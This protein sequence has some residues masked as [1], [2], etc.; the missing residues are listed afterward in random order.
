[1]GSVKWIFLAILDFLVYLIKSFLYLLLVMLLFSVFSGSDSEMP[2][3]ALI[4]FAPVSLYVCWKPYRRKRLKRQLLKTNEEIEKLEKEIDELNIL[5]QHAIFE[6]SSLIDVSEDT[7]DVSDTTSN[8]VDAS[9]YLK[10]GGP[11]AE[12]LNI[13]L[14]EGHDFESWCASL[15]L[16]IGFQ[17]ADVTPA[18]GDDGVDIIAVKDDIRYAIQCKRYS[19]DLGNTPI[20]E[21]YTGK[22]IYNC[23][24][25]AVMTNQYFTSGGKRAAEATGTLLWD[26][27][28]LRSQ[29]STIDLDSISIPSSSRQS[30]PKEHR[31]SDE[32]WPAAV[33]VILETGQASVS[34]LQRRMKLGYARAA[35]IIDELEERGV[36]GPFQGSSPR[37]I[38]ITEEQWQSYKSK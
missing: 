11:D 24:V 15:L 34:M 37:T 13:D 26:R 9:S 23:H 7:T 14:M 27:D 8:I 29:L 1:M 17:K 21:V 30:I 5:K 32:L 36:V 2:F 10:Y 3:Y 25:G 20:Q 6:S 4:V 28:W 16:K 12:L 35:R 22:S 18:S 31:E 38:L 33:D 19:S